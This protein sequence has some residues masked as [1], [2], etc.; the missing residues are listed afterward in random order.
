MRHVINRGARVRLFLFELVH[1]GFAELFPTGAFRYSVALR[2]LGALMERED[3]R[4]RFSIATL[5]HHQ[6][7][8]SVRG[9]NRQ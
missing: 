4:V 1:G 3:A 5:F 8:D 9:L 7:D 2:V 6:T